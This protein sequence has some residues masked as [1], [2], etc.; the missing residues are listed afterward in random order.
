MSRIA[1]FIAG[2]VLSLASEI[3][4]K[5]AGRPSTALWGGMG[6]LLLRR[7]VL[8]YSDTSRAMLCV[9]GALLLM[10]MRLALCI[11]AQL[12]DPVGERQPLQSLVEPPSFSYGLYRFLL[13]AP[14]Y[15]IIEYVEACFRM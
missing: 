9:V 1:V 7:V 11:L 5:G 13:I 4:W 14:A 6:M 2:A 8:R 12:A 10:A 3:F 15:T